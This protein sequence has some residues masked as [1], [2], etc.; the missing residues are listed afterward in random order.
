MWLK[1]VGAVTQELWRAVSHSWLHQ[2]CWG[3]LSKRVNE[4]CQAGLRHCDSAAG[5]R[6]SLYLECVA[7][8]GTTTLASCQVCLSPFL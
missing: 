8:L 6:L 4:H 3:V 5:V 1:V 7:V 2:P